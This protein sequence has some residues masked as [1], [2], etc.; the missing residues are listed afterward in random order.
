MS[1]AAPNN[2]GRHAAAALNTGCDLVPAAKFTDEQAS[3]AVLFKVD[4]LRILAML[5]DEDA[6]RRRTEFL[7]AMLKDPRS[8]VSSIVGPLRMLSAMRRWMQLDDDARTAAIDNFISDVKASGANPGQVQLLNQLTDDLA[9]SNKQLDVSLASRAVDE[10]LPAFQKGLQQ[11]NDPAVQDLLATLEGIGRR[12]H[13]MGNPIEMEGTLLDGKPLDW[14]SYRGKVVLIDFWASWCPEC[15]KEVPNILEAHR[16]YHD[17]G[18]EVVGV[19]LDTDRKL[20]ETVIRQTGM[21]WSQ[22]FAAEPVG[23]GWVHPL[24]K[25]YAVLGIPRAIL[26]DQ[27]GN[28]VSLLARGPMLDKHLQKL[29]G[30][31]GVSLTPNGTNSTSTK[32]AESKSR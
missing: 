15:I 13:L 19:C 8:S 17:K 6:D 5:G 18:F 22:L 24:Q 4:G 31:P 25:K 30:P 10:L 11:S 16:D 1:A 27:K 2:S 21:T 7:N 29:L 20:A 26:V 12:L 32:P 14:E 28:V 9:D 23:N 3:Q